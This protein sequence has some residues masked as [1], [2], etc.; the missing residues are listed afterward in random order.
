MKGWLKWNAG[1]NT[2]LWSL[3][4]TPSFK[5]PKPQ[6][7]EQPKL[8]LDVAPQWIGWRRSLPYSHV[9][10][11]WQRHASQTGPCCGLLPGMEPL[12]VFPLH[13]TNVVSASAEYQQGCVPSSHAACYTKCS[14]KTG[15]RYAQ[16]ALSWFGQKEVTSDDPSNGKR[17][18]SCHTIR[19]LDKHSSFITTE[20]K[21]CV[22]SIFWEKQRE[23]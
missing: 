1:S 11:R 12:N 22:N 23:L 13:P 10:A 19:L 7:D 18:M 2:T 14:K 3:V 4:G 20:I 17:A 16:K 8:A 15:Y 9:G 21:A 5:N 6:H